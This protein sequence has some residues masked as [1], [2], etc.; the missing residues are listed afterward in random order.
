MAIIMIL[1]GILLPALS[2]ARD[3]S[4]QIICSN[5]LKQI[6]A[7][8]GMY[9]DDNNGIC[10]AAFGSVGNICNISTP[11]ILYDYL[12]VPVKSPYY[13]YVTF[14]HCPKSPSVSTEETSLG[15]NRHLNGMKLSSI[16]RPSITI[17]YYDIRI[18]YI[19][20][21]GI[22]LGDANWVECR[23]RHFRKANYTIIDG[24]LEVLF[25][26]NALRLTNGNDSTGNAIKWYPPY[27]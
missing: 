27:Q 3:K 2:S 25:P 19:D 12:H 13:N 15:Y 23:T 18:N 14:L 6:V 17:A 4:K 7:A 5:N 9:S 21:Y 11:V 16:K 26:E 20:S 8:I 24:H 1:A 22:Y 10:P